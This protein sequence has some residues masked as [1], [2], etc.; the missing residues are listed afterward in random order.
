MSEIG[1][2]LVF[3]L[4]VQS[5]VFGASSKAVCHGGVHIAHAQGDT[6]KRQGTSLT[7]IRPRAELLPTGL[8]LTIVPSPPSSATGQ[9]PGLQTSASGPHLKQKTSMTDFGKFHSTSQ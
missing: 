5:V 3:S 6:N 8:H 4:V 9:H 1:K 2:L 7:G